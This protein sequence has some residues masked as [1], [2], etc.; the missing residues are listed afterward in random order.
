M[1]LKLAAPLKLK[2]ITEL[3]LRVKCPPITVL[4]L[5]EDVESGELNDRVAMPVGLPAAFTIFRPKV[6]PKVTS[7]PVVDIDAVPES[8]TDMVNEPGVAPELT[9]MPVAAEIV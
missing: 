1:L 5:I 3:L 4:L 2:V 6:D 7:P 8:G 9:A